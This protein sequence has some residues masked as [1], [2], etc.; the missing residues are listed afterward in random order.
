MEILFI[1]NSYTYYNDQPDLLKKIVQGQG[2][3]AEVN[4]ITRGSY[5]LQQFADG[6]DEY[7]KLV[8]NT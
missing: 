6:G 4:S 3:S 2:F 5:S 7:G 8:E 1:G